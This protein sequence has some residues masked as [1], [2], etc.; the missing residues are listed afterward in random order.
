[1]DENFNILCLEE[2]QEI[3]RIIHSVYRGLAYRLECLHAPDDLLRYLK[4]DP[5]NLLLINNTVAHFSQVKLHQLKNTYGGLFIIVIDKSP[6]PDQNFLEI[7][8]FR[9]AGSDEL[10][11]KLPLLLSEVYSNLM[12]RLWGKMPYWEALQ[13]S[14]EKLRNFVVIV[15]SSGEFVFVNKMGRTFLGLDKDNI[16]ALQIQDFLVDGS[17]SWNFL[18]ENCCQSQHKESHF[19]MRFV[20]KDKKVFSKNIFATRVRKDNKIWLLQEVHMNE[21]EEEIVDENDSLLLEKF[22]DSV[23]N[24]LLNP[25]NVI[26]GRLHLLKQELGA[27]WQNNKNLEAINRQIDRQSEIISKLLTF[28]RLKN[29][30]IPQKVHLNEVLERLKLEPSISRLLQRSNVRLEFN[31]SEQPVVLLGQISHFDLLL[32]TL[33]EVGFDCVGAGGRIR[34]Q[35]IAEEDGVSVLF[36]LRY[37]ES[38]VGNKLTL[39][40]FLGGFKSSPKKKSIETTIIRQIIQQYKATYSL[41]QG[42]VY[43]ENLNMHFTYSQF[44]N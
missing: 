18:K 38:L 17:K 21:R 9:F 37:P 22:A 11:T 2:D 7:Q 29:D 14:I 15:F 6:D 4:N 41:S 24:E 8:Q 12:D 35:T 42:D 19:L 23:A 5:V 31:L 13:D 44:T 43:T 33:L 40:S 26:S 34:I 36:E 28:A 3:S 27:D 32:K 20:N 39:V 1:M 30:F 25:V 16:Q 10:N